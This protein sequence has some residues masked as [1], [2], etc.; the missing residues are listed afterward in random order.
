MVAP[1]ARSSS[2]RLARHGR[3]SF[4]SWVETAG[5]QFPLEN[6]PYGIFATSS[7]EPGRCGVA[8]GEHVLD[9]A[10]LAE[11]GVFAGAGFQGAPTCPL[12]LAV[13]V[14]LRTC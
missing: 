12:R 1:L 6:L 7:T 9:L 2:L 8:I 13:P 11:R 4:S 5:T 10:L 3:R 14:A